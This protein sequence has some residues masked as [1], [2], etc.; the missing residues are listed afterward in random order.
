MGEMSE[1]YRKVNI[2]LLHAFKNGKKGGLRELN[3]PASLTSVFGKVMNQVVMEK[4]TRYM[5]GKET[6][7]TSRHTFKNWKSGLTNYLSQSY[8]PMTGGQ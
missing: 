8:L 5:K 2:T 7:R 6:I 4:I 3:R 1:D